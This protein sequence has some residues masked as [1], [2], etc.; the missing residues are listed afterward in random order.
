MLE[1]SII[2]LVTIAPMKD[3][4]LQNTL[5][6]HGMTLED[7][8]DFLFEFD[9]Q[10]R[11]YDYIIDPQKLNLFTSTLNGV[12]LWWFM[13]LAGS[14]I[15]LWDVMKNTFLT[16]YEDYYRIRDLKYEIFKM[17]MKDN[18]TIEEYVEW[19]QYNL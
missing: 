8:N 10:C 7:P 5:T 2:D 1:Y 12:A 3:I 13:G 19:F 18:E 11:G 14:T 9:V 4:P 15:N 6:F 17:P 16:K